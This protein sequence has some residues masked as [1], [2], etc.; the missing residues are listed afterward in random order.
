[1]EKTRLIIFTTSYYPFVGGVETAIQEIGRRLNRR[2]DVR[3]VTSRFSRRLPKCE[4]RPEGKV[5][6]VGIGR[7]FDKWLLPFF[8]CI[9]ALRNIGGEGRAILWGVDISQGSVAA[10][11]CKI[12][13]PR[14]PFVLNI[15]Y[16]YGDSRLASGRLGMIGAALRLMLWLAD[17]VTVISSYLGEVA[18]AYGYH[19]RCVLIHNGVNA[20]L[21]GLRDKSANGLLSFP[22]KR[23]SR[24]STD[25]IPDQVGND[26]EHAPII[27]TTSRLVEKNG[28]DTLVRAIAVLKNKGK[29]LQCHILGDGP[30]R[31][32][33]G[34]LAKE[35]GVEHE[36]KFFGSVPFE[37]IPA[38]LHQ[39]T[40]FIRLSRSEGMG[41]SFVEALAAGVPIIGT[42]VGGIPDII[43]DGVTGLFAK[44]DDPGDAA[45]KIM[46][47]L[48]DP[49]LSRSIVENGKKMIRERFLWDSIA[50]QYEEVFDRVLSCRILVATG[51]FPPEIGGP[52]TYSKLLQDELPKSGFVVTVLPFR[53]VRHLPKL[54]RHGAY[55]WNIFWRGL[56]ADVIFAQ[57][58]VSVGAPAALAAML[59]RKKFVLKIVGDYAWEQGSQ[60][61]GV[62]D[63]LDEFLEKKYDWKV[64]MLR[65]LE[66]WVACRAD[67]IVV[68]SEYL[69]GVV[70]RWGV[71]RDR[72]T[73]IY[74]AFDPPIRM[75]TKNEAREKLGF[76]GTVLISV[77]RLVPWKG[78]EAVIELVQK[79]RADVP[80]RD[81]RLRIIGSGPVHVEDV[82][83]APEPGFVI[84]LAGSLSHEDVLT[85]LI[86]GDIFILN[87]KYE[88]FSHAILE[89]MALG[90]PVCTTRAGG[91]IELIQDGETGLF[92]DWNNINQM[93]AAVMRLLNDHDFTRRLS[94]RAREKAGSFSAQ[95]ML[96]EITALLK[97]A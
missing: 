54:I 60:R 53:S 55:F 58:P 15:Q 61:F 12:L 42:R 33:L 46:R 17:E 6:R 85:S 45:E 4:I 87:T 14:H 36:I 76:S 25:W 48:Q 91:N 56:A 29:P 77:G 83:R 93:Q 67:S 94:E 20:D 31:S 39:A 97:N 88:G 40:I 65:R 62:A 43:T 59:T 86:A 74:N 72:I 21:F 18:A 73:V 57:D 80:D 75:L 44:V 7:G 23:E 27:I 38:H 89:A 63:P 52:A 16:G 37:K 28:I 47:L 1:M 96:N 35:L 95:R 70:T 41:V 11:F 13:R 2:F 69:R 90:I 8:G 49:G 51:L 50:G 5:I 24:I 84:E 92:F 79:L 82:I 3:I 30:D 66:R 34:F 26:I 19:G 81:I 78:F 71:P 10:F 68:P 32:A 9:V 64:E 22:R